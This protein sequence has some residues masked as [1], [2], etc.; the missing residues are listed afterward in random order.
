MSWRGFRPAL[1]RASLTASAKP[2]PSARRPATAI[3]TPTAPTASPIAPPNFVNV[4]PVVA[5]ITDK[6]FGGSLSLSII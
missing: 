3:P 6:T 5:I 2:V 4:P 1:N